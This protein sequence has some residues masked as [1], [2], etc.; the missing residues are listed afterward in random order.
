M[1]SRL[2]TTCYLIVDSDA[3]CRKLGADFY[4]KRKI[5]MNRRLASP[6]LEGLGCQVARKLW[7]SISDGKF[8]AKVLIS[9]RF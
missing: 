6:G 9:R 7:I 4:T 8:T 1:T 3:R 2:V 5:R